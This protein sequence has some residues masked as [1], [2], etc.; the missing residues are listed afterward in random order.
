MPGTPQAA[1][2]SGCLRLSHLSLE[3][4]GMAG[5]GEGVAP[6]CPI[7]GNTG[8]K[9]VRKRPWVLSVQGDPGLFHPP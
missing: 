1:E 9:Q 4:V 5:T 6:L 8:T 3:G 2:G 7:I